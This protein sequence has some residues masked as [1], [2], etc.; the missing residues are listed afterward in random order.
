MNPIQNGHGDVNPIQNEPRDVIQRENAV[1][2]DAEQRVAVNIELDDGPRGYRISE[3][4]NV[5]HDEDVSDDG[6]S[7][8]LSGGWYLPSCVP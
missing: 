1:Q 8:E 5:H 6:Q 7:H 2:K 4:M 3:V